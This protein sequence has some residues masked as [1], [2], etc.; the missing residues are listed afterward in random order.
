MGT[1]VVDQTSC[2]DYVPTWEATLPTPINLAALCDNNETNAIIDNIDEY[3]C[4]GH[5]P[6]DNG[7]CEGDLA[8]TAPPPTYAPPTEP[9]P[10]PPPSN[11]TESDEDEEEDDETGKIVGGIVGG[12]A[13]VA[14]IGGIAY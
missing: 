7:T 11:S 8:P 3:C 6:G 14:L 1:W 4:S 9:T 5:T 10:T 13:G 12:V 2:N